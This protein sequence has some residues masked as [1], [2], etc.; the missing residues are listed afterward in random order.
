M[1]NRL[2]KHLTKDDHVGSLGNRSISDNGKYLLAVKRATDNYNEFTKFKQNH[3][4]KAVL[5]HTTKIQGD[6][7]L[8][9]I[10]LQS[11]NLI[12]LFEEFKKNDLVG[13]AITY[14]FKNVGQVSPSTIRYVK[15][16]SDILN[17]FGEDIGERIA[18]IGVGYGGQML[19]IDKVI[20]FKCYDLFDLQ[21]VLNL[22]VKYLE[23]QIINSA[24]KPLT[25]NQ[26]DGD[27]EYDLVISNYAFSELPK[28]LQKKYIEKIMNKSKRGY[29]TMNSGKPNS[30]FKGDHLSLSELSKLLPKFDVL[31]EKPLTFRD[32]YIIVW[33]NS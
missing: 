14:T 13:G 23:S 12:K 25:L 27:V 3:D 17:L 16:L 31:D 15:V 32:N 21:P 4:Y 6:E 19:I 29:L 8:E 7:Y 1:F 20:K 33:N 30:A 9:A 24:Y 26:H 28:L 18:E 5:E 2:L 22:A 11:P 10:Q